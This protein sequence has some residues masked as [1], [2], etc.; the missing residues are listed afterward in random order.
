M[1]PVKTPVEKQPLLARIGSRR[2]LRFPLLAVLALT[3]F[4]IYAQSGLHVFV[5]G[6]VA[7]ANTMNEN[8]TWIANIADL[9][10]AN[11]QALLAIPGQ[12][13]PPGELATGIDA[14]GALICA[15]A[16]GV[17]ASSIVSAPLPQAPVLWGG[18]IMVPPLSDGQR[19]RI[20]G[21]ALHGRQR[22]RDL[23]HVRD[24]SPR[25]SGAQFLQ[26][27]RARDLHRR[28]RG[29]RQQPEPELRVLRRL[30]GEL[31]PRALG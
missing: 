12:S 22:V 7:D 19:G 26:W 24:A 14:A 30:P 8:F 27:S 11:I 21:G 17:G 16:A 29:R 31:S 23:L 25:V 6:T 20:R 2:W 15:V 28:L 13:C 9:L 3:P 4:A 1:R 10:D 18:T 5:N